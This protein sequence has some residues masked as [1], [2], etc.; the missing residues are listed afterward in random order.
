VCPRRLSGLEGSAKWA[1][2]Y[3]TEDVA[4]GSSGGYSLLTKA[5]FFGVVLTFVALYIR[6]RREERTEV[7]YEKTLA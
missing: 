1:A 6:M 2:G 3:N 4:S 5:F 7:G